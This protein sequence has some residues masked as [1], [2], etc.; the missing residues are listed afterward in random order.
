MRC[1]ETMQHANI[2]ESDHVRAAK[3]FS[4]ALYRK[5]PNMFARRIKAVRLT[6]DEESVASIVDFR[7]V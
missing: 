6:K 7:N 4:N 1:V 3:V 2:M 5:M